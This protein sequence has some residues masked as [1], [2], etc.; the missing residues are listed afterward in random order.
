MRTYADH[1]QKPETGQFLRVVSPAI[2]AD[3]AIGP[4]DAISQGMTNT[5]KTTK[6]ARQI[7]LACYPEYKGRKISVASRGTY[8]MENYWD[9]GSRCYAKAYD[10]ATGKV[11]EPA[12]ATSNPMNG[13]AHAEIEI[14]AGV[15]IV[16][17]QFF[18]GKDCG[19][20]ILVNPAAD[21]AGLL[22]EVA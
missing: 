21:K 20:T 22:A 18:C 12:S 8:R 3:L 11:G 17:H 13:Q 10:L 14:P 6:L 9:G 7:A 19:I 15:A 16:E 1:P 5:K 2:S 4:V